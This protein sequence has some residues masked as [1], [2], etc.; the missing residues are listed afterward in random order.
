MSCNNFWI[1]RRIWFVPLYHPTQ[2]QL[3]LVRAVPQATI[4]HK[5]KNVMINKQLEI[6]LGYRFET[7]GEEKILRVRVQ[8]RVT[9]W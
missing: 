8:R 5:K 4:L 2:E 7:A 6:V 3:H 1:L 9:R